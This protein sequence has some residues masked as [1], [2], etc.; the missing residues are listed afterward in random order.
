MTLFY[1]SCASIGGYSESLLPI[2]RADPTAPEE[3]TKAHTG[4]GY[5]DFNNHF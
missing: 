4:R 1:I 2:G 3:Q 5:S